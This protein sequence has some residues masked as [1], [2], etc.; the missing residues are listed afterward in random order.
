M[1]ATETSFKE[2][3]SELKERN[4][5]RQFEIVKKAYEFAAHVHK[6]ETFPSGRT[7]VQ[8]LISTAK[9]ISN[10]TLNEE[11][12]AASF[13][14]D[15]LVSKKVDK[16]E[17][18]K[19][20]GKEIA[21]LVEQVQKE[22][23]IEDKNVNIIG[24]DLLSKIM[25]ASAKDI[26]SIFI[27]VA[28]TIDRL[29]ENDYL[30]K[31]IA[32]RKALIALNVYAPICHKLG[33]N[34]LEWLLEDMA[35]KQL[36]LSDYLSVKD[37]V[38]E[39]REVRQKRIESVKET[40][41]NLVQKLGIKTSIFGRT[42]NF[43]SIFQKME[44]KPFDEIYDFLGA[45]IICD[46]VE[47]CYKVLGV[48]NSNFN[49][50]NHKFRD[51]ISEPKTNGYKSIHMVI[52]FNGLPVEVQIR[53]WQMHWDDEIGLAAHWQYKKHKQ[54]KYFDR[55]LSIIKQL[56]EWHSTRKDIE[57]KQSLKTRSGEERIFVFT[58]RGQVVIL[59]E[60]STPIDFAFAIHSDVGKRAKG[61]KVNGKAVQ[62]SHSLENDEV[63]EIL[64]ANQLQVKRSWL[65]F[66][67]TDKAKSKIRQVL[68]VKE[69]AI[70]KSHR[71]TSRKTTDMTIRMANCCRPLPGDEIVGYRTTKRKISV[72]RKSCDNIK[73]MKGD[74]AMLVTWA[75]TK[76]DYSVELKVVAK[77][78]SSLIPEILKAFSSN[79]IEI[80][81]TNAKAGKN[82]ITTCLFNIK[83]K[84]KK[85]LDAAMA[86]I[87][88]LP[89]VLSVDRT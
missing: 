86:S 32:D 47:D 25:L 29:M 7:S 57:L 15:T 40:I 3:S 37:L 62:L 1:Q 12:L 20:F 52:L 41:S 74:K 63:V 27:K 24:W 59:K 82:K 58:P 54:D 87:L 34:D 50:L 28:S 85:Q 56:M 31:E 81:S 55:K 16:P 77:E 42:K 38:G 36:R 2:L 79:K 18:E 89:F 80:N 69:P 75:D 66:V 6:G 22:I 23:N 8:H 17:L 43:Y 73:N 46:S 76:K 39:T 30:R 5:H 88:S 53:T 64:T 51:Y 4:P 26:R 14:H 13:L 65:G 33:L 11:T 45:R 72:H 67:K 68:G 10:T 61:A 44:K 48:I 78:N 71:E 60:D 21:S 70:K 83:I 49:D 84:G 19:L 35:F 9:I